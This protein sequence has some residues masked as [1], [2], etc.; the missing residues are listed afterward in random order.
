M[1]RFSD[2]TRDSGGDF[3]YESLDFKGGGLAVA[4]F[5]GDGRPDIIASRRTGGVGQFRNRGALHFE[6][7]TA[8]GYDA[9]MAATAIAAADL[10]NDGDP[11]LVLADIG[12]ARVF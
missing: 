3:S 7:V 2:V 11:D 6:P 8:S 4:D 9:T 12:V 10:D 5:D 1:L